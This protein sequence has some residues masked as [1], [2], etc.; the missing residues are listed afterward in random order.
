MRRCWVCRPLLSDAAAHGITAD[1]KDQCDS[2]AACIFG[3]WLSLGCALRPA[4]RNILASRES[5]S[6][7]Q[8]SSRGEVA[9]A[10]V[11][12]SARPPVRCQPVPR[13]TVF[14]PWISSRHALDAVRATE[15]W[16]HQPEGDGRSCV[17]RFPVR[18]GAAAP[19]FV[20]IGAEHRYAKMQQ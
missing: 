20:I 16:S 19:P 8:E 3:G 7:L 11:A 13:R 10:D 9:E 2:L 6:S 18:H 1:L 4:R 12:C 17:D 5:P 15:R 14:A